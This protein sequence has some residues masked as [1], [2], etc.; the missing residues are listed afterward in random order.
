MTAFSYADETMPPLQRGFV[1]SIEVMTGQPQLARLYRD[2]QRTSG[3]EA[4]WSGAVRRL[5]L[6]VRF[7]PERLR[8]IPVS[9]PVVVVAN[10]PYGV[11]DGIVL[12]WLSSQVRL[13]FRILTN[14]VLYRAPEVRPWLLPVDFSGTREAT[15]TNIESRRL[16]HAH[17][18][19]GGLV[20]VFPAGGVSTSPDRW[21]RLAAQDAPWQPFVAQLVQ[22]HRCPVQP[23]FFHGQNSRLFQIASHVSQTLRLSLLFKEVRDRIDTPVDVTI[24]G[25][26]PFVELASIGDRAALCAHLR[27]ATYRLAAEP[28]AVR[29][30]DSG[31]GDDA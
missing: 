3:A 27:E 16:A 29:A 24:G 11:L 30:P 25:L 19:G 26:I 22:R 7:D 14:A 10:H 18:A 28:K 23:V 4:F 21:G 6:H 12:G 17:L 1:R 20:L 5:R 9:G 13:D 2:Y 31:K 8:Q 15:A